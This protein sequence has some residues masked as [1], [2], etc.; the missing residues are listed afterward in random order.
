MTNT[1]NK[2]ILTSATAIIM[3]VLMLFG[4][5]FAYLQ[6]Q[7]DD[8]VNNFN[9][10]IF[11]VDIKETTG[12]EYDI[13]PGTSQDKD[14][15][16]Y[17]STTVP[18]YVFVEVTDNTQGLV[19]YAIADGWY[20]L[21]KHPNVY[22]REIDGSADKQIFEVLKDN[23]VS[24][25]STI[26][27]KDML[28][29]NGD[30]TFSLKDGITLSFKALAIQKDGFD[31]IKKAY[32]TAKGVDDYDAISTSQLLA[33][34]KDIVTYDD[35]DLWEFGTIS[36]SGVTVN[37][38]L[39]ANLITPKLLYLPYGSAVKFDLTALK[40]MGYDKGTPEIRMYQYDKDGNYIKE[41]TQ[42]DLAPSTDN[43]DNDFRVSNFVVTD[44]EGM[45]V[46]FRWVK[47]ENTY[48]EQSKKDIAS[49]F[50]VHSLTDIGAEV[51]D[52][53]TLA[54][55]W[56]NEAIYE[57][58]P[59]KCIFLNKTDNLYYAYYPSQPGHTDYSGKILCRT[60][61]DLVAWSDSKVVWD[62]SV[63]E[64]ISSMDG[65]LQTANGDIVISLLAD[66]ISDS[67]QYIK[68]RFLR[69]TDNGATWEVEHFIL[70]GKDVDGKYRMQRPRVME[71]GRIF[72]GYFDNEKTEKVSI[73]Y[74]ED[75]GHTWTSSDYIS[76]FGLNDN[77]EYDFTML[78]NGNILCVERSGEV[79]VGVSIST[80]GGK[81]FTNE[82]SLKTLADSRFV[83]CPFIR[84]D[85]N[86]DRLTI[87]EVDRFMSGG[88]V[89]IHTSGQHMTDFL[90]NGTEFKGFQANV[91]SLG[92]NGNAD[93]GYC[94][95]IDA[96]DGTV[97]CFYYNRTNQEAGAAS[98][99][100]V[101]T[102]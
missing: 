65:A 89:A 73:C 83:N 11:N 38:S 30:G 95:I 12:S 76:S 62:G 31:D 60:S 26:T 29:D 68:T 15:T 64:F 21:E 24:Y 33:E 92:L 8:L 54:Q 79:G 46:R 93:M 102:R 35:Y 22:Y 9:P 84:Y 55:C 13:I 90:L 85:K 97:K 18:A 86:T 91:C 39:N 5:T 34:N 100:S 81:S 19:E 98:W 78:N 51:F 59:S 32:R 99:Y 67:N 1:K 47:W 94:H 27:N 25:S 101:S 71:D 40:E 75:N 53:S 57:A 42:T 58:W 82:K 36:T 28:V 52:N 14:P 6:S 56:E 4:G 63:N 16:V 3:A 43:V 44:K 49:V 41:V 61:S 45:Y 66:N 2:K 72:A 48:T 7:T 17:I 10:K 50:S 23:K 87:Y 69:S 96:P 77:G 20:P 70:D 74:S 80:D 88:L 37:N